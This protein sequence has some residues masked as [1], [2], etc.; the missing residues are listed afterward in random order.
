MLF[1]NLDIAAFKNKH[2][3]NDMIQLAK[4]QNKAAAL[5]AAATSEALRKAEES[6]CECLFRKHKRFIELRN[7]NC[8]TATA[9]AR[10]AKREI[11]FLQRPPYRVCF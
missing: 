4:D 11:K 6:N 2:T 3:L 5:E 10:L 7:A 1:H 8:S 9:S